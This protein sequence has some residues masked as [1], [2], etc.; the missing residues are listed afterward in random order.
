[1]TGNL[2]HAWLFTAGLY[3]L[4]RLTDTLKF[5]PA[6][7]L[8]KLPWGWGILLDDIA[9]GVQANLAAQLIVWWF[10]RRGM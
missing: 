10:W 6:R 8:E 2:W 3:L 9:A 4:F 1:M 7:Q 5:P